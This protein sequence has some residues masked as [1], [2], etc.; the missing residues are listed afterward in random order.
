M[1]ILPRLFEYTFSWDFLGEWLCHWMRF[2][3]LETDPRGITEEN[4]EDLSF[5]DPLFCDALV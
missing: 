2:G 3:G 4:P 5:A 1:D